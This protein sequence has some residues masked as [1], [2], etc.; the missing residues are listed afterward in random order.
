MNREQRINLNAGQ[1]AIGHCEIGK[2]Y[3]WEDVHKM[4][5][6]AYIEGQTRGIE[7]T[8]D[9]VYEFIKKNFKN[10]YQGKGEPVVSTDYSFI[11][12]IIEDLTKTIDE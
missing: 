5:C 8:A 12:N 7:V 2:T 9:K 11:E 4:L 3:D 1:Y 10:D 6:D